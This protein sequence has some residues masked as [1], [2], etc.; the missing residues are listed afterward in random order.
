MTTAFLNK[1]IFTLLMSLNGEVYAPEL[2]SEQLSDRDV[3]IKDIVDGQFMGD[4]VSLIEIEAG[5]SWDISKDVL[6]AMEGEEVEEDYADYS[7]DLVGVH[8]ALGGW[9]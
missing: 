8:N 7:A 3:L 6:E 4:F 2:D 9:V 5:R 1:P